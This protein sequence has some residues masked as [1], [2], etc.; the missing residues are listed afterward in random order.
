MLNIHFQSILCSA[1]LEVISGQKVVGVQ[2]NDQK[3][4]HRYPVSEEEKQIPKMVYF[5]VT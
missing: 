4:D 3:D 1:Y 2:T 5:C